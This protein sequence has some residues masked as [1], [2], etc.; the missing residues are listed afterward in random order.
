MAIALASL[1]GATI[2]RQAIAL[3]AVGIG[4]TIAVYGAVAVVVKLD[5]IGLHM[6]RSRR[7]LTRTIGLGLVRFV[8]W[9]LAALSSV[10]TAAMLWVGGGILVHGLDELGADALPHAI[11]DLAVRLAGDHFASD[12]VTWLANAAAAAI[13]ALVIGGLIVA[14]L[15]LARRNK[16]V[17]AK[18]VP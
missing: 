11:H 18:A 2:L 3:A 9:L 1:A 4:I 14:A 15:H 8:P 10:G 7:A 6:A 17:A 13:V 16:P 5:D 12:I